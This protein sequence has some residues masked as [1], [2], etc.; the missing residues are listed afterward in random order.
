MLSCLWLREHFTYRNGELILRKSFKHCKTEIGK[1]IGFNDRGYKRT[2][3]F[4][5]RYFLHQLIWLYHYDAMAVQLDHK[6]QNRQNNKIRNLRI[7]NHSLNRANSVNQRTNKTGFRGVKVAP[8]KGKYYA[9][10]I[11]NGEDIYLGTFSNLQIA[12][13]AYNKAARK[14]FGA[15]AFQNMVK[16]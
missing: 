12:A 10:I 4:G 2:R 14:H 3:L 13:L 1:A 11:V 7:C 9:R 5:K 16:K 8:I 6:D 15:F